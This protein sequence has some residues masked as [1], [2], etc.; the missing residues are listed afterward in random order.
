MCILGSNARFARALAGGIRLRRCITADIYNGRYI[1]GNMSRQIYYSRYMTVDI[2]QQIYYG[3]YI[4]AITSRQIYYGR[5]IAADVLW[6][7]VTEL[8]CEKEPKDP[9]DIP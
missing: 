9:W 5:Y 3:R 8:P 7:D 4:T 2:L 1:M 6:N